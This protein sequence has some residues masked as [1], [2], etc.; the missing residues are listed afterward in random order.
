MKEP[1]VGCY[2]I[3]EIEAVDDSCGFLLFKCG[4]A[5]QHG[6]VDHSRTV[7]RAAGKACGH[8]GLDDGLKSAAVGLALFFI[9]S[10]AAQRQKCFTGVGVLR[11]G[12]GPCDTPVGGAGQEP[13]EE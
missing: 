6:G 3:V 8:D 2:F 9:I 4:K 10:C 1:E 7:D 5:E 11:F 12:C 13:V